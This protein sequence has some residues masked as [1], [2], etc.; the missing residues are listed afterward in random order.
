M[1]S[2]QHCETSSSSRNSFNRHL[3]E[4]LGTDVEFLRKKISEEDYKKSQEA[5]QEALENGEQKENEMDTDIH[6]SDRTGNLI[7]EEKFSEDTETDVSEV[8][9]ED[10]SS[11]LKRYQI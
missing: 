10:I 5:K 8:T 7:G 11:I 3:R 4:H 9:H 2:C 1:Y 6:G